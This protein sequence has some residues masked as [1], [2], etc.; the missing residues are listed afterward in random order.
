MMPWEVYIDPYP[1]AVAQ[2][3]F[4]GLTNPGSYNANNP[5]AATGWKR[6]GTAAQNN[7]I[8]WDVVLSAGEWSMEALYSTS[9]DCAIITVALDD[10]E[11]FVNID[12]APYGGSVATIDT[13]S[14]ALTNNVRTSITGITIPTTGKYRLRFMAATKNA[15]SSNYQVNLNRI[16]WLR[17][18]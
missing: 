14:A 15:S 1:T 8:A 7:L 17:T 5:V 10:G 9:T 12:Q 18:T 16:R 13:Y 4:D 2:T 3:G 6:Q 11:G